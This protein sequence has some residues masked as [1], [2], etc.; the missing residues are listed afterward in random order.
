MP[1]LVSIFYTGNLP[2]PREP[3]PP[4]ARRPRLSAAVDIS[5]IVINPP[6]SVVLPPPYFRWEPPLVYGTVRGCG[7][8]RRKKR[9]GKGEGMQQE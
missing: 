9:E 7:R 2:T 4:R 6:P 5:T 8:R 3:C 1:D